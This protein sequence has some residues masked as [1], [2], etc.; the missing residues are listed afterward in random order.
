[1]SKMISGIRSIPTGKINTVKVIR[2][3]LDILVPM[4][5]VTA[6]IIRKSFTEIDLKF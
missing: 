3:Y 5:R 6:L 1:M 4:G 2:K